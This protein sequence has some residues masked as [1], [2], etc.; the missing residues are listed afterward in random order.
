MKRHDLMEPSEEWFAAARG[1]DP[2]RQVLGPGA[3]M[4]QGTRLVYD[5]INAHV[6]FLEEDAVMYPHVEAVRRLI[7]SGA[8][9]TAS[10]AGLGEP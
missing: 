8:V 1:I 2:S 10:Q 3:H 9:V 4:G 5:L 7:A 6:P